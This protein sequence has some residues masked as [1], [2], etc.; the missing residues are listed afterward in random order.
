MTADCT[1][2]KQLPEAKGASCYAGQFD[3]YE[4]LTVNFSEAVNGA[5]GVVVGD[6]GKPNVDTDQAKTGLNNLV[7]GFKDGTIPK[8]AI[9]YKEEDSRRAFEAGTLI[10][11][12]QWP[13]QYAL[14]NKTDGT[15]KVVGKFAVAPLPGS[16]GPGVSSLGGHNL[17]ISAYAKNK[18][19]SLDFI[20]YMVGADAQKANLLATSQAPTLT[21]LYDDAEL[22]KKF[23]YLPILKQSILSAKPRPKAVRYNA[24]TTAIEEDAYAAINGT[25]SVDDALS[26]LQSKLTQIIGS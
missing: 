13:Y 20:K 14:A 22:T 19:T 25:K 21:S 12:R 11:Q 9:T 2:V 5:G 8:A 17:A 7:Q 23:P 18:A 3:K 10:F 26:D 15:S 16:S 6:D 1:K 24:V 4:G